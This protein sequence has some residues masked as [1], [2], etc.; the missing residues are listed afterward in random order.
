MIAIPS[1]GQQVSLDQ[2]GGAS[3]ENRLNPVLNVE[4]ELALVRKT[5]LGQHF[6]AIREI[7]P[8]EC[9]HRGIRFC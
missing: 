5:A 6:T 8:S 1:K 4:H 3:P 9:L 7:S 2:D